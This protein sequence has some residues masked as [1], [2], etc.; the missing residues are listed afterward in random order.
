[1]NKINTISSIAFNAARP[2]A[3]IDTGDRAYK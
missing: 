2:E 3:G 1:M